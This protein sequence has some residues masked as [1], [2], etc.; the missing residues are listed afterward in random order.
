[1]SLPVRLSTILLL[2][3]LGGGK[4]FAQIT[5]PKFKVIAF[6]T[7]KNDQAHISYIKEALNWFPKTATENNFL[8]EATTDWTK[9]ND[10]FLSHYQVILFLD[11]SPRNQSKGQPSKNSWKKETDG[12]DSISPLLH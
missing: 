11:T 10:E 4:V 1:M 7:G 5:S 12:W 2:L 8:F 9:M 6:Y 3:L